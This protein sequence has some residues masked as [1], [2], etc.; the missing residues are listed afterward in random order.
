LKDTGHS[1]FIGA[2]PPDGMK[3]TTTRKTLS[4]VDSSQLNARPHGSHGD[5]LLKKPTVDAALTGKAATR[6]AQ[7]RAHQTKPTPRRHSVY[8]SSGHT[9]SVDPRP[10]GDN[11]Y[12]NSCIRQLISFLSSHGYDASLSPKTLASPTAKE[13]ASL[14]LF[15]FRQADE[16]FKFGSKTEDDVPTIFRQLRYPFQISKSALYAV[17]SQHTWPSLLTA[18]TWLVQM[19]V[20]EEEAQQ[21]QA[22]KAIPE[23]A[24]AFFEYASCSY[25]HFLSGDD[26]TCNEL[27]GEFNASQR[28][29]HSQ[30]SRGVTDL[31]KENA[32]LEARL[33][34]MVREPLHKTALQQEK[35][36]FE[37][38][39]QQCEEDIATVEAFLQSA[40]SDSVLA[41]QKKIKNSERLDVCRAAL[42]QLRRQVSLQSVDATEAKTID[43]DI[44][45]QKESLSLLE[46]LHT[47]V[48]SRAHTARVEA[49][50]SLRDMEKCVQHYN[51]VARTLQI[52]PH[53]A[54]YANETNLEAEI[55]PRAATLNVMVNL[56]FKDTV[57]TTVKKIH[58]LHMQKKWNSER[59]FVNLEQSLQ[60]CQDTYDEKCDEANE[61]ASKAKRSES[62]YDAER[63][64]LDD[65]LAKI[66]KNIATIEAEV[67][68]LR[69]TS[70]DN[71]QETESALQ[72]C[73]S[74]YDEC[75]KFCGQERL[76]IQNMMLA[77]L[78]A[79]M[80]HKQLI[81]DAL[82]TSSSNTFAAEGIQ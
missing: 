42:A 51:A 18:L 1:T 57:R 62:S 8:F 22:T 5:A 50:D 58:D 67:A 6:V 66:T 9:P 64:R 52:V 60:A 24:V 31:E 27:E 44:E 59:E 63:R 53:T 40:K 43:R 25:Q 68:S 48:D 34:S 47:D 7:S 41:R 13:F 82:D 4:G 37:N 77:A 16:N 15:L 61:L 35:E 29:R 12:I 3:S 28:E 54:K 72:S 76:A 32:E 17:G 30:I 46:Q 36:T 10:L 23:P 14:A 49:N 79:L 71:A 65:V 81:G 21:C 70:E 56:D 78:D 80:G 74:E 75:A 2:H 38:G 39:V 55:N 69:N 19:Y 33:S 11:A 45:K 26:A 20:Y 73:Q